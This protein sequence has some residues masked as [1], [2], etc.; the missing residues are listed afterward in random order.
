MRIRSNR[1]QRLTAVW[2]CPRITFTSAATRNV[3]ER[4]GGSGKTPAPGREPGWTLPTRSLAR[5]ADEKDR[6]TL[7]LLSCIA[8]LRFQE[9][10]L[11]PD[12]LWTSGR[13]TVLV[14]AIPLGTGN[15]GPVPSSGRRGALASNVNVAIALGLA[16]T[17]TQ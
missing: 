7:G 17:V 6:R 1:W 2:Q 12:Y 13:Y 9:D 4:P 15:T 10:Y 14:N 11:P 3:P 5:P 16:V 8:R